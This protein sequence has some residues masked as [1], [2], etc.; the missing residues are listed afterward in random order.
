MAFHHEKAVFLV[1]V[2]VQ[3]KEACLSTIL[4]HTDFLLFRQISSSDAVPACQRVA[5]KRERRRAV[6]E[7]HECPREQSEAEQREDDGAGAPLRTDE[8]PSLKHKGNERGEEKDGDIH[9]RGR[10]AEHAVIRIEKH[11]D[12]NKPEQRPLKFDLKE[13]GHLAK[14]DP[15][16]QRK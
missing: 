5:E 14:E 3:K 11:G 2:I 15:L 6:G 13:A 10:R 9:P 16:D 4:I 12:Q 8:P 1:L 7:E